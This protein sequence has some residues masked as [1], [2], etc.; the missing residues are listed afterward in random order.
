MILSYSIISLLKSVFRMSDKQES[1]Q[2]YYQ[3]NREKLIQKASQRQQSVYHEDEA[4]REYI[5]QRNKEYYEL[6][7]EKILKQR[8]EKRLAVKLTNMK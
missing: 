2:R 3:N 7:R 1:N 5:I 8:R 4:Q 6:N